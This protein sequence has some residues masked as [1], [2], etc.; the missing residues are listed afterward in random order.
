[1]YVRKEALMS[2]QIE[3]SQVTLDDLLNPNAYES[4]NIN[5]KE[6]VNYVK[7]YEFALEKLN[8]LPICNRLLKDTHYI[9]M[10]GVRGCDKDPGEFRQS[11][12]WIGDQGSTLK[13][14]S[15]IPPNKNDMHAALSD[16][17]KYINS[18]DNLDVIIQAALIHYQFETIHPFLDG[19]GRVGRLLIILFFIQKGILSN[20]VLYI[21][22][23]LK[24]NRMEYYDR[25]INVRKNGHFEEWIKFFLRAVSESAEDAMEKIKKLTKLHI[26]NINKIR[27]TGLLK[28]N[29]TRLLVYLEMHPII[30]TQQ[31]ALD[32]NLAFSTTSSMIKALLDLKILVG[33]ESQRNRIYYYHDYLEM[34][35]DGTL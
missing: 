23:F 21:S 34:L 9:L 35:K 32:L 2:A 12:N 6:V 22:Y 4:T 16:L 17:E 28:K 20:P 15:F 7:A 27:G 1:M 13:T 29:L 10:S 24:K 19:N 31:T 26:T 3:G 8:E 33:S 14:A 18:D 25:L 5:I 11:Q 30:N